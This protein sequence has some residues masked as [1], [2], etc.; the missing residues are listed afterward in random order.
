MNHID[1]R[2]F[3]DTDGSPVLIFVDLQQ[4]YLSPT[5]PLALADA[6]AAI[7][8]CLKLLEH[9]RRLRI[10]VAFVRWYQSAKIFSRDGRFSDWV[11]GC[12]PT[13]SDMVFDRSWPSCYANSQFSKM[14]DC[15]GGQNAVIAG[16][17]GAIACLATIVE[18]VPRQHRYTFISDA[19]ASHGHQ[20]RTPREMHDA[21]VSLISLYADVDTTD[22][23]LRRRTPSQGSCEATGW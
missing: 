20:S 23:W 7:T 2:S 16:F 9:A 17:T 10:P 12:T 22:N 6:P 8:N 5:R 4:E 14:M 18:G 13:G 3:K 21:A 15:G 1:I 19:S 11:E